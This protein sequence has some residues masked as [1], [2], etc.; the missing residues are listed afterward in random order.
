MSLWDH[1]ELILWGVT[2][3]ITFLLGKWYGRSEGKVEESA[4]HVTREGLE[5]AKAALREADEKI[6]EL[7]DLTKGQIEASKKQSVWFAERM[8]SK[9][10]P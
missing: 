3:T 5:S 10:N 6:D 1:I 7:A 9:T 2:I 8:G 4:K